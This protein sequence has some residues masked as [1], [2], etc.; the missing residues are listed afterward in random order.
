ML[1]KSACPTPPASAIEG[2]VETTIKGFLLI[3]SSFKSTS[4][5]SV[6]L[7]SNFGDGRLCV[8]FRIAKL[9]TVSFSFRIHACFRVSRRNA[10]SNNTLMYVR[11]PFVRLDG[12]RRRDRP[13]ASRSSLV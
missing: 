8:R 6:A 10:S 3:R 13:A 5:L 11:Y 7:L 1:R 9:R 2:S 4:R 12:A